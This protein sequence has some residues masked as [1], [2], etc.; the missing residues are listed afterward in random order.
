[1]TNVFDTLH[2][3]L[4]SRRFAVSKETVVETQE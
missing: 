4:I 2:K 3:E 1:M